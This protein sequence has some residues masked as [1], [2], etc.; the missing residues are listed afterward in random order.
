VADVA[1][2]VERLSSFG[3]LYERV[4]VKDR[5]ATAATK[6]KRWSLR[7]NDKLDQTSK[8]RRMRLRAKQYLGLHRKVSMNHLNLGLL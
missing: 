4:R 1:N 3:N 5:Q 2:G 6:E 7:P 8:S